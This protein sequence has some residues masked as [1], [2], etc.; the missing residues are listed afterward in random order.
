MEALEFIYDRRLLLVNSSRRG[1]SCL[2]NLR[3]VCK[4]RRE[5]GDD[6]LD[7]LALTMVLTPLLGLAPFSPCSKSGHVPTDALGKGNLVRYPKLISL[8]IVDAWLN[9]E[10]TRCNRYMIFGDSV[11]SITVLDEQEVQYTATI[12]CWSL[13]DAFV[14]TLFELEL[15][16]LNGAHSL[17]LK[18]RSI[19]C[20][21]T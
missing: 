7:T 9:R 3:I 5:S 16:E 20:A 18:I 21:M 13:Q 12:I 19:K 4:E 10:L 11:D 17:F 8:T 6:S 1:P 14:Q 2:I 15:I